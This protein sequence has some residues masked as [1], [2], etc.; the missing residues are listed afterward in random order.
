MAVGAVTCGVVV[1]LVPSDA[2]ACGGFFSRRSVEGPRRPSL[3]YEQTLI[4]F[5]DKKKHQHFIREVAFNTSDEAFGFV[6]PTPA[7]P[8]VDAVKKSPF[9]DL[10][11]KFPFRRVVGVFGKGGLGFGSGAARGGG[12]V[13]VLEKKRVGSFTAYVLAADDEKA[14]ASWL[15]KHQLVSTPE[16]DVWLKHY[17]D[18]KFFYVAMRYNPPKG[19]A[20]KRSPVKAETMRI[21]FDTPVPYYP[22]FEPDVPKGISALS[23]R[24]LELWVVGAQASVPVAARSQEGKVSWVRPLAEGTQHA[25]AGAGLKAALG[26]EAKL[27]PEGELQVQTFIDQKRSRKGFGDVLFVSKQ[28]RELDD[29]TKAM[30]TSYLPVL[31]PGLSTGSTK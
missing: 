18:M 21:S 19:A 1:S 30:L 23:Q 31:D 11:L 7:R 15:K 6:V 24:M 20:K 16:A 14:L 10:R 13:K 2:S 4:V 5:D 28:K 17:V 3:S 22:Y 8:Q 26:A 25:N 9:G 29:A 27:L 12:G